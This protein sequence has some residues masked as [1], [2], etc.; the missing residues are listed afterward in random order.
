[1]ATTLLA[2]LACALLVINVTT[3][4]AAAARKRRRA[5]AP[6]VA[7]EPPGPP[8]FDAKT[9]GAA[10]R[11][12]ANRDGARVGSVVGNPTCPQPTKDSVMV[13]C[14]VAFDDQRIAYLAQRDVTG[15]V[16]AR[17]TFPL[18]SQRELASAA[19]RV[20]NG[21]ASCPAP[22]LHVLPPGSEVRCTVGTRTVIVRVADATG[23][24]DARAN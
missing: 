4:P 20:A 8:G 1:M 3:E 11:V 13:Q 18:V 12:A 9:I 21:T 6:T 19:A 2:T 5:P 17:S 10:V 16:V 22:R 7:P 15:T 14:I 24:L 23:R